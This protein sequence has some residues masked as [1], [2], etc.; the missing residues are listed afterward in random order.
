MKRKI[1]IYIIAGLFFVSGGVKTWCK[2]SSNPA[3]TA[4]SISVDNQEK[5]YVF[6]D[7]NFYATGE[8][9]LFSIFPTG[10][11][12]DKLE[13]WSKVV[14]VELLKAD[15]N[16]VKQTKYPVEGD[17][18]QG[19]FNI[20]E[21]LLTGYYYLRAYTMWMRNF[22][23]TGFATVQLKIFN[24]VE[25]KIEGVNNN[26]SVN[27]E[28]ATIRS[29]LNP[30]KGAVQCKT[31]FTSYGMRKPVELYVDIANLKLRTAINCCVT[32]VKYDAIDSLD[33]GIL[34]YFN[35]NSKDEFPLHYI[36]DI[37]GLSLS[38]HVVDKSTGA[39][40][41]N[42][43][44]TLSVLGKFSD[45][46]GYICDENGNFI[47]ALEPF[48]GTSDMYISLGMNDKNSL[49]ILVDKEY[50][51]GNQPMSSQ[52]FIL[53]NK[54]SAIAREILFNAQVNKIYQSIPIADTATASDSA[55]IQFYGKP[56]NTIFIKDYID[57]PTIGEVLFELVHE[58]MLIHKK[59][60]YYLRSTDY[61]SDLEIFKP[62]IMMDN[63][64]ITDIDALLKMSPEKLDHIDVINRIYAKGD[65]LYGGLLNLIT[66]KGD[67][68]GI[69]L[70]ENSYFFSFEGLA[71][72]ETVSFPAYTNGVSDTK[73]PDFRNCLYWNPELTLSQ[74]SDTSIRFYTSDSKGKYL[75]LLRGVDENGK[76]YESRN[77]FTVE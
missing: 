72:Q 60:G 71:P 8:K 45:F 26:H 1:N 18:T 69:T 55:K 54:D 12:L 31:D 30:Q 57:L 73:I 42:A 6:T 7:R 75:V 39:A 47:L 40:A 32:V 4:I 56:T 65:Y 5:L 50:A 52:P 53:S 2:S 22:P 23:I 36:P 35:T 77:T 76:I 27:H 58:V 68:G 43:F 24:P 44:V 20:P 21:N 62:L 46:N 15:G 10:E 3:D 16:P 34:N 41:A 67:F 49:E 17:R 19:V 33:Y 63:I 38:G 48:Y 64:P 66:K 51:N 74:D 37:R 13:E 11:D 25:T 9:C 70:P 14:Y 29:T 59:D 28:T 61:Y